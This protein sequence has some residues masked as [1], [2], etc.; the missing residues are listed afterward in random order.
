M[1]IKAIFF[2]IVF[3]HV[4]LCISRVSRVS[5]LAAYSSRCHSR[6][7]LAQATI[8]VHAPR[9][10]QKTAAAMVLGSV[11]A[12]S[13]LLAGCLVTVESGLLLLLLSSLHAVGLRC[14]PL[15]HSRDE[16]TCA[17]PFLVKKKGRGV[18]LRTLTL[19]RPRVGGRARLA[20]QVNH[21]E[22]LE[23]LGTGSPGE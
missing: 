19:V 18:V 7:K 23:T 10:R 11:S 16:A 5:F 21:I 13:G 6:A 3:R 4:I 12:G 22:K 15:A 1:E 2:A 20:L 9:L 14:T 8:P 17:R